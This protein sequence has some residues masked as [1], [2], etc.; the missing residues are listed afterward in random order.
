MVYTNGAQTVTT[1]HS[2]G[3]I[4]SGADKATTVDEVKWLIEKLS[5]LSS[6]W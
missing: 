6:P 3:Y 2:K 1:Y 5:G 4:K